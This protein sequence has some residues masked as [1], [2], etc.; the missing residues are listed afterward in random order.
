MLPDICVC[1]K[2]VI[3]SIKEGHLM[4]SEIITKR[5]WAITIDWMQY[6]PKLKKLVLYQKSH[7][8]G[9]I[10]G[11]VKTFVHAIDILKLICNIL[12]HLYYTCSVF[13]IPNNM[14]Y[15][16]LQQNIFGNWIISFISFCHSI[17]VHESRLTT[18][19]SQ[20][21]SNYR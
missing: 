2:E 13:E 5:P 8:R 10:D 9:K 4:R 15:Y 12:F 1:S 7:L 16:L 3:H 14:S 11:N 19:P 21:L 18:H 20:F 17:I 6:S